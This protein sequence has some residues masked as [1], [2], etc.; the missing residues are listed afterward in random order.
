MVKNTPIFIKQH[1]VMRPTDGD[2]IQVTVT[3]NVHGLRA[4]VMLVTLID[5]MG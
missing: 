5:Q 4:L 1:F 2:N 3:I